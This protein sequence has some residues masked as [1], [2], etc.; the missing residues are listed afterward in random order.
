MKKKNYVK[1]VNLVLVT[2]MTLTIFTPLGIGVTVEDRL[3]YPS[4]QYEAQKLLASYGATVDYFDYSIAIDDDVIVGARG[5]DKADNN[6]NPASCIGLTV[7]SYVGDGWI[8]NGFENL[9]AW[10]VYVE[11]TELNDGLI[12]V[13]GGPGEPMNMTSSSGL[14]HNDPMYDSLQSPCDYTQPPNG[15][16]ANQWDTYV[17][18]DAVDCQMDPT[19]VSPGFGEQTNNL[20]SK[21][22]TMNA[23]WF[24]TPAGGGVILAG[25][26]LRVL[27]GQFVVAEG[28]S[29]SGV[30]NIQ[31]NDPQGNTWLISGLHV[32]SHIPCP[33]DVNSDGIV[34][35]LDLL[36]VLSVWGPCPGCPE[37]I[38]GD[39]VV[40]MLDLLEVLGAWGPCSL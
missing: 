12:A 20:A 11:F 2:L 33:P 1:L 36:A 29:I 30:L 28:D 26:D 38:N 10:R 25:W 6:P 32:E 14:F 5:Y 24:T 15:Y 3:S 18:M 22:S 40:D 35:V 27:I 37:D 31:Y 7:E 21:F 23:A 34:D 8:E 4:I 9:T 39:G 16:W 17:T 19:G 13:Y